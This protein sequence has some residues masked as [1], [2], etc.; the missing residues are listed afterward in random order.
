[1]S[2]IELLG[3]ATFAIYTIVRIIPLSCRAV[4]AHS[5]SVTERLTAGCL[6]AEGKAHRMP[7]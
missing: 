4:R 6:M 2:E 3:W 7:F 5:M 1:M